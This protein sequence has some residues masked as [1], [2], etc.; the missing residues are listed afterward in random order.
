MVGAA[1][2]DGRET[3]PAPGGLRAGYAAVE[4]TPPV[5]VDLTGFIARE[6]PCTG[7]RDPLWARALVFESAPQERGSP[8]GQGSL[9]ERVALVTCDLIG[10][11][12]H[13]VGRVRRRIAASS[14]I[15]PQGLLFNCS[16]THAGPETG[17]L[18]TIGMPHPA[19]LASLERGLG[20][21]VER[22]ASDLV[23]VRLHLGSTRV[24]EGL[25]LNRVYR[26][27][28]QPERYDRELVVLRVEPLATVVAFAC[29]AVALGSGE[30][31]ASADFVAPLRRE[32]EA[33][34]GG[35][36]LYLNGCGGDVNPA[37]MDSRG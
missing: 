4:I 18:T 6:G 17:V 14:G 28:G 35:P 11:G 16:H 33:A 36:L 34:G 3:T 25:A 5:G 31:N 20:D 10:L 29:H 21:A 13:L 23:P 27:V 37:G 8:G 9:G 24:P 26:R 1:G 12:R 7:T 30:R 32:L 19:Y 22:A 2:A 15:A